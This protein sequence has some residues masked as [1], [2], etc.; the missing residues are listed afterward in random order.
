MLCLLKIEKTT[1]YKHICNGL[2]AA[3]MKIRGVL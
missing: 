2:C 1:L 3:A